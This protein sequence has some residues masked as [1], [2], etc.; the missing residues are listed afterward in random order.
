VLFS[1]ILINLFFFG[2]IITF[3]IMSIN[4]FLMFNNL[5]QYTSRALAPVFGSCR[6]TPFPSSTS[7]SF[8]QRGI[9]DDLLLR[10]LQSLAVVVGFKAMGETDGVAAEF[11][12]GSRDHRLPT[13]RDNA[14]DF[15]ENQFRIKD[16]EKERRE[17]LSE[18]WEENSL[19]FSSILDNLVPGV[20]SNW[21]LGRHF[22]P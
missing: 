20:G 22:P 10:R 3:F 18:N 16:D 14:L 15:L 13:P 11:A 12:G 6:S 4:I 19:P 1:F 7:S 2:I 9:L 17:R 5:A 21:R 8:H